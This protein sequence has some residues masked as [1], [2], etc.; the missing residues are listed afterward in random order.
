ME[1]NAKLT[2]IFFLNLLFEYTFMK[3]NS[4]GREEFRMKI[5]PSVL[6]L[7]A[8]LPGGSHCSWESSE[9]ESIHDT[10]TYVCRLFLKKYK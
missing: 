1:Q 4:K 10:N 8:Q 2:H 3:Q 7:L 6:Q 5:Y 9:R